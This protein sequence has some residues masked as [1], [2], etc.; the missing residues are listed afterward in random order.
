M[1]MNA[2]AVTVVLSSFGRSLLVNGALAALLRGCG[3]WWHFGKALTRQVQAQHRRSC[4]GL[5]AG[6][7]NA[8]ALSTQNL[9]KCTQRIQ[10]PMNR[11]SC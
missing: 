8:A 6:E 2:Q 7:S 11:Q 10:T 3:M 1:P 5:R 4:E 9:K